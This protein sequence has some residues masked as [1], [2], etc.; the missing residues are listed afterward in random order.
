M[1]INHYINYSYHFTSGTSQHIG[2]RVSRFLQLL[3]SA[4][5]NMCRELQDETL[6][7]ATSGAAAH[8]RLPITEEVCAQQ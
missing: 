1:I 3:Q 7:Q 2:S 6:R 4:Q 5:I 8:W